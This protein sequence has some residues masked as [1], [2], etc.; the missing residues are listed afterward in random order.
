LD[1]WGFETEIPGLKPFFEERYETVRSQL[2]SYEHN[3]TAL[4]IQEEEESSTHLIYPNPSV[5]GL[6]FVQPAEGVELVSVYSVYGQQILGQEV[7]E[8]TQFELDLTGAAAG[9]YIVEFSGTTKTQ[10]KIIKQ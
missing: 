5:T 9:I 2:D 1:D 8:Q 6:F 3:C 10:H 7:N 4:S